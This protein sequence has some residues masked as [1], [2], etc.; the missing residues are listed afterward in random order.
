MPGGRSTARCPVSPTTRGSTSGKTG[1]GILR[2]RLPGAGEVN[3]EATAPARCAP[4][5]SQQ[6]PAAVGRC[7]GSAGA[8][9]GEG[10]RPAGWARPPGP[11]CRP[12]A[13]ERLPGAA[14]RPASAL[15]RG[16]GSSSVSLSLSRAS[17]EAFPIG[18]ASP[19]AVPLAAVIGS[20]ARRRHAG[21]GW[22]RRCGGAWC[23]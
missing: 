11:P 3:R 5:L 8:A 12:A 21:R 17:A 1:T 13:P 14:P 16:T 15:P 6:G 20:S 19:G 2:P 18:W 22:R 23:S 9:C 10:R 7:R 4:G